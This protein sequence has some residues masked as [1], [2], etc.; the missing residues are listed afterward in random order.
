MDRTGRLALG[1]LLVGLGGCG[2]FVRTEEPRWAHIPVRCGL[3][4]E[5]AW[6]GLVATLG[7]RFE[8]T[9]ADRHAAEERGTVDTAWTDTWDGRTDPAYQVR[10]TAVYR[11][12]RQAVALQVS[13][14]KRDGSTW[15]YG[16]DDDRLWRLEEDLQQTLGLPRPAA[17]T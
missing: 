4:D 10:A 17:P 14:R 8:I 3:P 11:P 1:L 6:D 15:V 13:A 12:D 16:R 5:K 9:T 2:S 7:R